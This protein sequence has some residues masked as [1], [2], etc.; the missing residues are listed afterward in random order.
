MRVLASL[1]VAIVALVHTGF[2]ML[3][4][5]FRGKPPGRRFFGFSPGAAPGPF[6]PL[7]QAANGAIAPALVL[8][9]RRIPYHG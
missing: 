2:Q 1:A 8:A 7:I 4:M 6:V 9:P 5:F 3:E